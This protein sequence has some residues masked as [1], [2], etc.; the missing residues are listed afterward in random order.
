MYSIIKYGVIMKRFLICAAIA[1]PFAL[2]ACEEIGIQEQKTVIN[3]A[4]EVQPTVIAGSPET[5]GRDVILKPT[6]L[7]STDLAALTGHYDTGPLTCRRADSPTRLTV[8]DRALSMDGENCSLTQTA[9]EGS[10]L[11]LNL[12]CIAGNTRTERVAY[13]TPSAK[14]ITL[15]ASERGNQELMRCSS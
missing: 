9:R 8:T 11:K 4:A 13:V 15:R 12:S 7:I 14:G 1:A 6:E 10:A 3:G 2:A 5:G